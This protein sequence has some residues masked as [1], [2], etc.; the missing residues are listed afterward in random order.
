[1][2]I[3]NSVERSQLEFFKDMVEGNYM[4][5]DI[6]SGVN[7]G[8]KLVDPIYIRDRDK[9][10]TDIGM[11][12]RKLND[13]NYLDK[14]QFIFKILVVSRY[15]TIQQIFQ[16]INKTP[17]AN[18]VRFAFQKVLQTM[19]SGSRKKNKTKTKK[20][21]RSSKNKTKKKKKSSKKKTSKK[22]KKYKK[23]RKII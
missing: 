14:M 10:L 17:D 20:K 22:K 9:S 11:S 13:L 7:S 12:G 19:K 8:G 18:Q 15:Y 4:I 1:M 2:S 6:Y 5:K 16:L 21:R 3:L 23:K